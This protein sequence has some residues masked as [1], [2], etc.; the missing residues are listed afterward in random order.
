M[1]VLQA[2]NINIQCQH[3]KNAVASMAFTEGR[4]EVS[5]PVFASAFAIAKGYIP[6]RKLKKRQPRETSQE[7]ASNSLTSAVLCVGSY[8]S[9]P[10]RQPAGWVLVAVEPSKP[11]AS[12]SLTGNHGE[13]LTKLVNNTNTSVCKRVI[14]SGCDCSLIRHR[15]RPCFF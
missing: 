8:N 1:I 7:G 12:K 6:V 11:G 2:V 14:C 5:H 9:S 3:R 4:I 10:A 15:G 13:R